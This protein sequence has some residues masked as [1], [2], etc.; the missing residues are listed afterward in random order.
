MSGEGVRVYM[1]GG[2]KYSMKAGTVPTLTPNPDPQPPYALP[3]Q[4][5]LRRA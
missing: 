5:G 1:V 2:V 3:L 4:A